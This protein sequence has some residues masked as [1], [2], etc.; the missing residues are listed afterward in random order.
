MDTLLAYLQR[1]RS[2][3]CTPACLLLGSS[4]VGKISYVER[5]STFRPQK[6]SQMPSSFTRIFLEDLEDISQLPRTFCFSKCRQFFSAIS[7]YNIWIF[8]SFFPS[9]LLA[10]FSFC[11][12]LFH[13]PCSEIKNSK[14]LPL[15]GTRSNS[16]FFL[17][18]F[19]HY[20]FADTSVDVSFS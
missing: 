19:F 5:E 1:Q 7:K 3:F 12:S 10:F 6:F 4:V 15:K 17:S 18:H 20:L 2:P 8:L 16:H 14:K 13:S 9:P 11:C